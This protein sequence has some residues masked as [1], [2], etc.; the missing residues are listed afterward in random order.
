MEEISE[1]LAHFS[2]MQL[3]F[4]KEITLDILCAMLCYIRCLELQPN[5]RAKGKCIKSHFEQ[6]V[7]TNKEGIDIKNKYHKSIL[8]NHWYVLERG[9]H[10]LIAFALSYFCTIK[11]EAR[12][13]LDC[14][15]LAANI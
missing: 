6:M 13:N 14:A 10:I 2:T 8:K 1:F 5:F 3:C 4:L 15:T 12:E 9:M 11:K 7:F